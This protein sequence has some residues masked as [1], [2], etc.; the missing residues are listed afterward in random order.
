MAEHNCRKAHQDHD[1]F[2]LCKDVI[3]AEMLDSIILLGVKGIDLP[4][5]KHYHCY[6]CGRK[7]PFCIP[8][9]PNILLN[10]GEL[11]FLNISCEE[12]DK[13]LK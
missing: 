11:H 12:V 1:N 9:N 5:I 8:V 4:D 10:R 6:N 7:V 2:Y 3:N 13:S